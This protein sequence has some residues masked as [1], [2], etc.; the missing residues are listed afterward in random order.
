MHFSSFTSK[1][2]YHLICNSLLPCDPTHTLCLE[3]ISLI[4]YDF[5]LKEISYR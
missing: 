4:L 1:M 3:N 5:C 2:I